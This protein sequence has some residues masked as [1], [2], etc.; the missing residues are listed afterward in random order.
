M[1]RWR[2]VEKVKLNNRLFGFFHVAEFQFR[3]LVLPM[4]KQNQA[5]RGGAYQR[6]HNS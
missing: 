4:E 5:G 6:T 1:V 3:A 2:G